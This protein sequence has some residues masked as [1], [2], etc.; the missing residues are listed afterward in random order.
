MYRIDQA[1]RPAGVLDE[2]GGSAPRNRA[3]SAAPGVGEFR[4]GIADAKPLT[5]VPVSASAPDLQSSSVEREPR[6]GNGFRLWHPAQQSR[7]SSASPDDEGVRERL[8]GVA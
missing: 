5:T 6:R 2:S 1:A 3:S 8:R 4:G 7:R